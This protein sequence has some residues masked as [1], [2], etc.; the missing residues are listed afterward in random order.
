MYSESGVHGSIYNSEKQL[1]LGEGTGRLHVP[2]S[3]YNFHASIWQ[4]SMNVK[5]TLVKMEEH[6]LSVLSLMSVLVLMDTLVHY[7]KV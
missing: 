1:Y 5:R 6:A 2:T 3:C 4:F 7:V